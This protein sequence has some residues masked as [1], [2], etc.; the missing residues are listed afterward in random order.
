MSP[1]RIGQNPT[2][3]PVVPSKI[4]APVAQKPVGGVAPAPKKG[5]TDS[6]FADPATKKPV[7][8]TGRQKPVTKAPVPVK[9]DLSVDVAKL[10][11]VAQAGGKALAKV[12]P[13]V[14]GALDR[15]KMLT[16]IK[17]EKE[18]LGE[19]LKDLEPS[20]AAEVLK[21][22]PAQLK[23]K[24]NESTP[25][26]YQPLAVRMAQVQNMSD[27]ELEQTAAMMRAGQVDDVHLQ[28][29]VGTELAARTDWGRDNP[30]VVEH[31]RQLVVDGKVTFE[32]GRGAGRTESSGE[33]KMDK[34]L[35]KSPEALAALLAHE[36]THS[37]HV[38]EG[39]MDASVYKEETAGN[40]ASARVWG[41][42]GNREDPD[43]TKNQLDGLNEYADLYKKGGEDG[44]QARVAWE[45]GT[46]ASS[47]YK[48][49]EQAYTKGVK[50]VNGEL[51]NQPAS[52][53]KKSQYLDTAVAEQNKVKT[54]I[55]ELKADPGAVKYMTADSA[56]ALV[57]ASLKAGLGEQGLK[58]LGSA[59]RAL[60]ADVKKQM[61]AALKDVVD[62][63]G[64]KTFLKEMNS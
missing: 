30:D 39:G 10:R 22:L 20:V 28:L 12:D 4:D 50:V 8:M 40:V 54:V 37:K 9:Q 32:D 2:T 23:A 59:M 27:A 42:I 48:L 36:A 63:A 16:P 41:Q 46:E 45:Y 6:G 44:V 19:V 3:K 47:K 38:A 34:S 53:T 60:P 33:I 15:L 57:K 29:A 17:G 35:A 61:E 55:S 64:R 31:Q 1:P 49:Y 58:D 51:T 13:E 26:G 21:H 24:I 5:P 11:S 52:D 56:A 62:A 7:N 43:L 25:L 14:K 18:A